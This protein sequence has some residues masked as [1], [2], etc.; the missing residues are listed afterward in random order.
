MGKWVTAALLLAA[1]LLSACSMDTVKRN[2]YE[3]MQTMGREQCYRD[4]STN[5]PTERES[6]DIYQQQR[7]E[8]T[9]P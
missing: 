2:T 6:Y 9:S 4:M 1:T 8:A 5:C 3:A 7:R